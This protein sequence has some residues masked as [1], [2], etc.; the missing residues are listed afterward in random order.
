MFVYGGGGGIRQDIFP[1]VLILIT[2]EIEYYIYKIRIKT[3]VNLENSV[4]IY[5]VVVLLYKGPTK[6]LKLLHT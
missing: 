6:N 3:C 4:L 5:S 2:N 1:Y